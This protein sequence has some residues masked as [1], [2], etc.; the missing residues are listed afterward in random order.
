MVYNGL[1]R[2]DSSQSLEHEFA[3]MLPSLSEVSPSGSSQKL[4]LSFEFEVELKPPVSNKK[5]VKISGV[6]FLF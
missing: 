6:S 5:L 4:E 3:W 2:S 1:P